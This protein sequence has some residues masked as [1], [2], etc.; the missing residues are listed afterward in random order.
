MLY[1]TFFKALN[2]SHLKYLVAGGVAV[3]LHGFAR[4]TGDLDILISLTD[5][6]VAK[7]ISAV[8][9]LGLVPRL[10]VKIDDFADRTKRQEWIDEKNMRVFSVYNPKNP[11][12]HIDVMIEQVI[13]F[14]E[15]YKNRV[16]MSAKGLDIPVVSIPDLIQMKNKDTKLEE[17]D[18]E[19]LR[20]F[21]RMT[22]EKKL[23]FLEQLQDFLNVAMPPENKKLWERLKQEGF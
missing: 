22:A 20:V 10:P 16:T 3:N 15:A 23:E 2:A 18:I 9:Q 8:K 6:E 21:S 7:F 14:E 11:M 19:D 1:E 4:A 17:P 13:N 12:E 5:P